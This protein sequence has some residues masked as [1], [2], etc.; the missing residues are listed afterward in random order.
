[1][2]KPKN[3]TDSSGWTWILRNN[4]KTAKNQIDYPFHKDVKKLATSFYVYNIPNSVDAKEGRRVECTRVNYDVHVHE[5]KTWNINIVDETLD[6]S[7]NLDVN[8]MEKVEDSVDENSLADLNDLKE[9]INELASNKIQHPI[10]KENMDQEDDINKV[11]PKIVV[12]SDLSWPLG[13]ENMKRTSRDSLGFNVRSMAHRRSGGLIYMW[14]PNSFIKDD[15]WCD[16]AFIIVKGHWRNTVGDCYMINIY[17][18]QDLLAKAI[19]WT[20]N[21]DFMHQYAGKYI[22][23]GDMNVVRNENERSVSL[24][25]RHDADNFNS[26]IDNSSLIDLPL[27]GHLFTWMN[28]AGTKLSKLDPFSISKVVAE[29]LPDVR[30]TAIDRLWSDHNPI[31]LHVFGPTPFKLFHSWLLHDSF[32]KVIKNELP[33]LEEH[34]FGRKLLSHE[35]FSLLKARIKQ[36]HFETKTSHRFTKHDNLQFI[37]SIEEKIEAGSANNGDRDSR[38]K[39]L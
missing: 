5:L 9:T 32:D 19:L 33:K 36:W 23:F 3:I 13:F 18:P 21:S 25:S 38:I 2:V 4:K 6:S 1:M 37:K 14:D 8:G 17:S 20:R 24:F 28:K 27:G 30:V 12:S 29:A 11:S 39:L 31:L 10:S 35:K 15:I 26:F 16:D 34:N 22:I 7:D